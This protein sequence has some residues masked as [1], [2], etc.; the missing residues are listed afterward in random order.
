MLLE[1]QQLVLGD[2][3]TNSLCEVMTQNAHLGDVVSF[4][5]PSR[6]TLNGR[7]LQIAPCTA[8]V[9]SGKRGGVARSAFGGSTKF[10]ACDSDRLNTYV[11]LSSE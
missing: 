4:S 5:G 3:Q 10:V 7:N 8:I 2:R 11:T 6:S 9:V 1:L